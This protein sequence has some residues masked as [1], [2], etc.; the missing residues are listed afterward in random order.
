[1]AWVVTDCMNGAC[2]MER[3]ETTEARAMLK[4]MIGMEV[5]CSIRGQ[6]E[7]RTQLRER[8]G[9]KMEIIYCKHMTINL[10]DL[11]PHYILFFFYIN[12]DTLLQQ[13]KIQL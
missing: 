5:K 1:M 3:M 4:C 6:R 11:K 7:E 12:L 2:G 13:K 10:K 8:N 9:A